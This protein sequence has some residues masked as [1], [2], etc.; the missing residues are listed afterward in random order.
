MLTIQDN[1]RVLIKRGLKAESDSYEGVPIELGLERPIN[2]KYFITMRQTIHLEMESR[3]NCKNYPFGGFSSFRDCDE[4]FV[5]NEMKNKH[6]LM[7][8]WAAKSLDEAEVTKLK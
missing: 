2:R 6:K 7:P 3:I 1:E 5:Y 8:F 4:E